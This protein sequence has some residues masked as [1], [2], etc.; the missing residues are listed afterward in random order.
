MDVCSKL[1]G[2]N[3]LQLLKMGAAY[4]LL[5]RFQFQNNK[6]QLLK[7]QGHWVNRPNFFTVYIIKIVTTKQD[8]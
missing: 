5:Q 1:N 6:N 2:K 7:V 3:H 8:L 4:H